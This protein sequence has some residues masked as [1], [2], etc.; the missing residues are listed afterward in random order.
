MTTRKEKRSRKFRGLKTHGWGIKSHRK[1]G[2]RGGFGK[3]GGHKHHWTKVLV[4][5]PDY[6]GKGMR[7]IRRPKK[8]IKAPKTVN[9]GYIEEKL[10]E[11]VSRKLVEEEGGVFKVDVRKLGFEKV[12][13]EGNV[14]H[15]LHILAFKFSRKAV[16]KIEGKGG[17]VTVLEG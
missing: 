12:L 14:N 11:L 9:L 17:K 1:S 8:L 6:F 4:E 5:E 13:G 15:K 3:A 16:E 2:Y 7:G 10:D